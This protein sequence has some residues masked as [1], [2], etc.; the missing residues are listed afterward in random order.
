MLP[1]E[2][3]WRGVNCIRRSIANFSMMTILGAWKGREALDGLRVR[4]GN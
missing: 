4:R 1:Q 3:Y 2:L